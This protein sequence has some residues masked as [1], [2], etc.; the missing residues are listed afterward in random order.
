[1]MAKMENLGAK[2]TC[3]NRLNAGLNNETWIE[4]NAP[5]VLL[6]K[7]VAQMAVGSK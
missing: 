2:K 5:E 1:M 6:D 7:K 4:A 3:V